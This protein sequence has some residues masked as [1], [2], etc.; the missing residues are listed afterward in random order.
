[1]ESSAVSAFRNMEGLK[2]FALCGQRASFRPILVGSLLQFLSLS[3]LFFC[4]DLTQRRV[5]TKLP[6]PQ[7]QTLPTTVPFIQR[8]ELRLDRRRY[9]SSFLLPFIIFSGSDPQLVH[10]TLMD[11]FC[12]SRPYT[13]A[14]GIPLGPGLYTGLEHVYFFCFP[15]RARLSPT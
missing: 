4:L 2:G 11:E 5:L 15:F 10:Y 9:V 14:R 12:A 7:L 8:A 1:M 3:L 13:R 6:S